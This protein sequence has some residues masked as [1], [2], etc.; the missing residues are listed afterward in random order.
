MAAFRATFSDLHELRSLAPAVNIMALTATAT[1]ATRETIMDVLLMNHP[2]VIFESPGKPNIA[3][4]VYYI[5][6]ERSLKDYFQ[7]LGDELLTEKELTTRTIIY[8]QTI[9]QCGL[10]YSTLRAML[11]KKIFLDETGDNPRDAIMEMLH[12]C[13]PEANK[14][15]ISQS[16]QVKNSSLRVLVATIAFGVGVDCKGV[17]RVIHFGPSKNI[18]AYIQETGR[19][20]RNGKQSVALVVYQGILLTHV[21][22]DMKRYVKT[23]ECRRKAL[24]KYFDN[25]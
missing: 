15:A 3:Y 17:Y 2:H 14:A 5:P 21:E 16:F 1:R 18:E 10:I 20:G 23:D 11:G 12:S 4:S 24:L 19:A 25:S 13:I 22:K 6:K 8:C 9:K 7:W